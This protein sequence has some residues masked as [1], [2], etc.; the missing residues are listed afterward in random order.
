MSISSRSLGLDPASNE[1]TRCSKKA[2]CD[3]TI[4]PAPQVMLG[5]DVGCTRAAVSTKATSTMLTKAIAAK[6]R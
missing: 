5:T 1:L 3:L 6:P 4:A 2:N